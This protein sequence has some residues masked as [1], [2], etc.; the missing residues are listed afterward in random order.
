MLLLL[1]LPP[2]LL[3]LL[4]LSLSPSLAPFSSASAASSASSSTMPEAAATSAVAA[5][6]SP[7][8][9][10]AA[11]PFAFLGLVSQTVEAAVEQQWTLSA[12]PT[13]LSSRSSSPNNRSALFPVD[14]EY[15]RSTTIDVRASTLGLT[16]CA[17]AF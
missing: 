8:P 10:V 16:M 9:E 1:L 3:L 15:A 5:T 7:M 11:P 6:S 2:L 12:K 14:P 17:E 13:R 4:L